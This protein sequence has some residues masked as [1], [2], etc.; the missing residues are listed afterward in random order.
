MYGLRLK[1][2][3]I[4]FIQ[5]LYRLFYFCGLFSRLCFANIGMIFLGIQDRE[6]RT[7]RDMS[8]ATLGQ[9]AIEISRFRVWQLGF[10]HLS[11]SEY[12][13]GVEMH[14]TLLEK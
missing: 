8:R 12:R 11:V 14:P 3:I 7:P 4:Q 6:I 1:Y 2:Y 10:E 5:D 9:L 13:V